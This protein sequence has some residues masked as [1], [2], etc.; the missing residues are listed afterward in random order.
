[1]LSILLYLKGFLTHTTN[2]FKDFQ[3]FYYF[4]WYKVLSHIML[5]DDELIIRKHR[6]F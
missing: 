3:L 2:S 5:F 1:M 6:L 4:D